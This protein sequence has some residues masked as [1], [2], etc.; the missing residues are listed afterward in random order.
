MSI[1]IVPTGAA[2]G[3][4]I[5]GVNLTEPVD[6]ETFEAIERAYNDHAVSAAVILTQ[7]GD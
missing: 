4:E 2:L 3:A 1:E 5:R 6:D 7:V